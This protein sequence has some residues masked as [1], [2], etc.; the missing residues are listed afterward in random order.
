[1][2]A[3]W[4]IDTTVLIDH[5]RGAAEARALLVDGVRNGVE[6]WS[7]VVVRTEVLAGTRSAETHA[8]TQ[9]LGLL[10]WLEITAELADRA[11]ALARIY[12]KSHRSID[13]VDYLIAASAL[14]LN[15][16]LKTTNARH[17]PM[18]PRLRPA[19]HAH[20]RPARR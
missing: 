20:A 2:T 14:E 9:L 3:R 5:L 13:T 4:L 17:F 11:G 12:L 16:D 8:T 18:F 7:S 19:Y 15:A 1:M 6:F 10:R